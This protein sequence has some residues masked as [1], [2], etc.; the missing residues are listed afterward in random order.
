MTDFYSYAEESWQDQ[1]VNDTVDLT[2][3][4]RITERPHVFIGVTFTTS[5]V[6]ATPGAGTY[7]LYVETKSNP[8]VFQAVP[9]ETGTAT[10][11]DATAALE[12]YSVAANVTQ[13]RVVSESITTT[14]GFNITVTANAG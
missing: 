3:P 12:T 8:G 9:T 11:I 5:G 6:A 7:S 2:V 4:D 10:S 13:I 1:A 14:D